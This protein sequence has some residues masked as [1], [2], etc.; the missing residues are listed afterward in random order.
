MSPITLR[1][2]SPIVVVCAMACSDVR[3]ETAPASDRAA[4][5]VEAA[6]L[7]P[8]TVEQRRFRHTATLLGDGTVLV[9]GGIVSD[10]ATPV[11]ERSAELYVSALVGFEPLPG[12]VTAR[13]GHTA[14]RLLDGTVL[15]AGGFDADGQPQAAAELYLPETRSFEGVGS[16]VLPRGDHMATLLDDGRVLVVDQTRTDVEI[17][18]PGERSFAS[19]SPRREG[20]RKVAL[21]LADGSVL[22]AGSTEQDIFDPSTNRFSPLEPAMRF[23]SRI[24]SVT[25]VTRLHEGSLGVIGTTG[26]ARMGGATLTCPDDQ[27]ICDGQCKSVDRD[28]ENCGDCGR[29]C[30]GELQCSGG[31]CGC[32]G[33][34]VCG[35]KCVYLPTD[36]ANCRACGR[37]C[38]EN[39]I[40][41]EGFC[42]DECPPPATSFDP[43]LTQCG[44]Y[45]VDLE[46]DEEHCGACNQACGTDEICREGF[47]L[48]ENPFFVKCDSR[49]VDPRRDRQNCGGCGRTCPFTCYE[50]V[51][52][53][54]PPSLTDCGGTCVNTRT[55][56]SHCGGC[57]IECPAERCINGTCPEACP[58]GEERCPSGAA[59]VCSNPYSDPDNCGGCG[60]ACRR[61]QICWAGSCAYPGPA[62]PGSPPEFVILRS[63]HAVWAS[64]FE[65]SL[66]LLDESD[67]TSWQ[68]HSSVVGLG[69]RGAA[70]RFHTTTAL[71]DG[72]VLTLGGLGTERVDRNLSEWGYSGYGEAS[73]VGGVATTLLPDGRALVVA[74]GWEPSTGELEHVALAAVSAEPLAAAAQPSGDVLVVE[75]S[76]DGP[77]IE[78]LDLE[79]GSLA[80]QE[81]ALESS[82]SALALPGGKILVASATS[83]ELIGPSDDG[84]A[85][86]AV[87]ANL[88]CERPVL[89]RLSNGKVLAVGTGVAYEIDLSSFD[90]SEPIALIQ[91]RCLAGVI[92]L[93]RGALLV[94][95][96]EGMDGTASFSAEFYNSRRRVAEPRTLTTDAIRNATTIHWF[97]HPI[98]ATEPDP[99]SWAA[100]RLNSELNVLEP[101]DIGAGALRILADGSILARYEGLLMRWWTGSRAQSPS[102]PPARS[103]R[104][105]AVV[106]FN[107]IFPGQAF[108]GSAPEGTTGTT[109]SSPTN[110]P[111][112]VWFPAEGGW[113]S[114]GTLTK[115]GSTVSYRVPR[116]PFP[117]L[118]LFFLAT[119]GELTGL[120]PLVIEP[121]TDGTDCI[122]GGECA[123]GYCVDGFCCD[124]AC[125]SECEACSSAGKAEGNDGSCGPVAAGSTDDS[126]EAQSVDTCGHDGTCDARG[127]CASYPDGTTCDPGRTCSA[128]RCVGGDSPIP[129]GEAGAGGGGGTEPPE[130][131]VACDGETT[132]TLGERVVQECH[133]YR[134][135]ARANRCSSPCSS[136]RDCAGGYA[137][138]AEGKC[139]QPFGTN[140][141]TGCGCRLW[142][143]DSRDSSSWIL[144]LGALAWLVCRRRSRPRR[145]SRDGA[146]G[147]RP[148]KFRLFLNSYLLD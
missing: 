100:L 21:T 18:E 15:L 111:V 108:P 64:A 76:E 120:G 25:A 61:E 1:V 145:A 130:D 58:S 87:A 124:R 129:P 99:A 35:D 122:D 112:A 28:N 12:L 147:N 142:S 20:I 8:I 4:P 110:V 146:G 29:S 22:L 134:C 92:P 83:L 136:N 19:L 105:N 79:S 2:T 85:R 3:E 82:G 98:L 71:P 75:R 48:C 59:S 70:G 33:S 127:R 23:P 62:G 30:S 97:D 109:Q 104:M 144:A 9:A 74:P 80:N 77:V 39:Q 125:D 5:R 41:S 107:E 117:G 14:T 40:C 7:E 131:V 67:W 141:A 37:S 44:D 55:D 73:P 52:A 115:V 133:P 68:E 43:A 36:P 96:G 69:T 66:Y 60:H 45:C 106:D 78:L 57:G 140:T 123:S 31:E 51:C 90:L 34:Y 32:P 81:V 16:M 128:G 94:G 139:E 27:I 84:F 138:T 86:V 42:R 72:S 135:P 143:S 121:S 46:R 10:E 118:G 113:P 91:P 103:L 56:T 126:C 26:Y 49:C 95:G 53:P 114:M 38:S 101:T 93:P 116:T 148:T 11:P 6:A 102:F 63:C 89:A 17:Y 119:N 13:Y 50:G 132:L 88:G 137:C 24:G 47:C 65:A 54:C